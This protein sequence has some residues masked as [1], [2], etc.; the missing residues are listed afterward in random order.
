MLECLIVE[1]EDMVV[2]AVTPRHFSSFCEFHEGI[3]W[4]VES[5]WLMHG[6]ELFLK[7][8]NSLGRD[9]CDTMNTMVVHALGTA[10]RVMIQTRRL[11]GQAMDGIFADQEVIR[12][13]LRFETRRAISN[14][15]RSP[16]NMCLFEERNFQNIWRCEDEEDY[17]KI[18]IA[19]WREMQLAFC[20]INH[21][22]LGSNASG[23]VLGCDVIKLI[24]TQVME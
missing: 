2:G 6:H 5:H 10:V 12:E 1:Y 15:D 23:R 11:M 24:L 18:P 14:Q 17:D 19:Q 20:M 13:L 4:G 21:G 22:R 16:T 8:T 7:L 3:S 9:W